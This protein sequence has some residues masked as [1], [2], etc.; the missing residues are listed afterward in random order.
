MLL[1]HVMFMLISPP[2]FIGPSVGGFYFIF[3]YLLCFFFIFH[4]VRQ[5]YS[6]TSCSCVLVDWS[7]VWKGDQSKP[8][9]KVK[10]M[11]RAINCTLFSFLK[12]EEM[13]NIIPGL[14]GLSKHRYWICWYIYCL[15]LQVFCAF[16]SLSRGLVPYFL[17]F[18]FLLSALHRTRYLN[19]GNFLFEV[20]LR[21]TEK[22]HYSSVL[23]KL[24]ISSS[25]YCSWRKNKTLEINKLS[26]TYLVF[27]SRLCKRSCIILCEC[28]SF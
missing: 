15:H 18:F 5:P 19:F 20:I 22:C 3:Y 6:E 2:A 21:N 4:L 8:K 27:C 7:I 9:R 13:W 26:Y 23:G 12:C 25:W 28:I 1:C 24:N 10:G 17:R 11:T 16:A 14:M